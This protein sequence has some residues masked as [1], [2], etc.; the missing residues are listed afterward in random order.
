MIEQMSGTMPSAVSSPGD[1]SLPRK[2]SAATC[3]KGA[4]AAKAL[5]APAM[6]GLDNAV[7]AQTQKLESSLDKIDGVVEAAGGGAAS[8][9][10]S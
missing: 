2:K 9:R 4:R 5:P 3:Q 1:P 8:C 10:K 6:P 7:L